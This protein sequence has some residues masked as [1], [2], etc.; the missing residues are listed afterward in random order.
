MLEEG[1]TIDKH[2][3]GI[4]IYSTEHRRSIGGGYFIW[5]DASLSKSLFLL[6][7]TKT[8]GLFRCKLVRS[9][10]EKPVVGIVD[11]LSAVKEHAV[12]QIRH[13]KHSNDAQVILGGFTRGLVAV[14]MLTMLAASWRRMQVRR[15]DKS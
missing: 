10:R 11:R 1:D 12:K 15:Y 6:T 9:R 4:G 7:H 3:R 5:Q 14:L 2:L 8:L 13:L